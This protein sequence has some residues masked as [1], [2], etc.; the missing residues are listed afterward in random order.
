MNHSSL[1]DKRIN[2]SVSKTYNTLNRNISQNISRFT[3][4]QIGR[5]ESK[6]NTPLD[7]K[8]RLNIKF[9]RSAF[10]E[11]RLDNLLTSFE[12]K[13]SGPGNLEKSKKKR[14]Q[15]TTKFTIQTLDPTEK[16]K[17]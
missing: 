1:E 17:R 6:L 16:S 3:R 5:K 7:H 2:R 12:M 9:E 11:T 4:N 13:R 15:V 10:D 8:E 14:V